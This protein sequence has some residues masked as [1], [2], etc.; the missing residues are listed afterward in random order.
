MRETSG[1][2]EL[3]HKPF[4]TVLANMDNTMPIP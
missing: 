4:L 3:K 2:A 1:K